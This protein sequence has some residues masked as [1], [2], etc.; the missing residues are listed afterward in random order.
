MKISSFALALLA[1][2]A[3]PAFT[4]FEANAQDTTL[5]PVRA[6]PAPISGYQALQLLA[7]ETN[8]T[9][10]DVRL[11]LYTEKHD[12]H[13]HFRAQRDMARG[14]AQSLGAERYSNLIAGQPIAL[15][16][17]AVLEAARNMTAA[18]DATKRDLQPGG[19]IVVMLA[20]N[21]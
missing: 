5:K 6:A 21:P 12:A 13:Y 9:A 20:A 7:L 10:K 8:L 17:P 18:T 2:A 3:S 14:F 1:A 16:S 4:T 19:R 11:V 15:Y